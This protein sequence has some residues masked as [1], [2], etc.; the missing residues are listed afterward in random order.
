MRQKTDYAS[1]LLGIIILVGLYVISLRSYILFHGLAEVFS[2]VIAFSIFILAW[3][4]RALMENS[5]LLYLGIAYLFIGGLDLIHTFAYRGMGV[6][7]GHT[8]NLPTQLWVAARYMESFSLL[9]AALFL[10]RRLKATLVL[11]CYTVIS[12]F[13]VGSIFFWHVFPICFVEG[14]G[15]TA[16]KKISEYAVSFVLLGAVISIIRRRDHFDPRVLRLLVASILLT[17]ASE[18]AFTFYIH[19]YGLSNLI[20]HYLKIVSFYLIY[21]ALIETGLRQPYN[22]LFRDLKQR[23]EQ[24]R[25]SEHRYRTLFESTIVGIVSIG[26]DR[27]IV[28]ANRALTGMLGYRDQEEL[29]GQ[30]AQILLTDKEDA[31]RATEEFRE[32]G[33]FGPREVKLR[34]KQG[35]TVYVLASATVDRDADGQIL[36]FT[37]VLADITDRKKAEEII[38]RDKETLEQMV[39][40]RS[41]ELVE[42][43]DRLA[44]A[45]RLSGIGTL[46]AT[47][48]HELRNPLGVIQ[49]ALINM[50]RKRKEPALDK[51]FANIEKKVSDSTQII[52]NLLRYSRI[53]PPQYEKANLFEILGEAIESGRERFHDQQVEVVADIDFLKDTA[54]DADILQ[55]REVFDNIL[56]NAYQAVMDIRGKIEIRGRVGPSEHITISMTDNGVGITREDLKRVFEPFF[57]NKARGTGLGLTICRELV[58]L[59]GGTV[60]IESESGQGTTVRVTLP[61]KRARPQPSA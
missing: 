44:E 12:V 3:N 23:E 60:E 50:K 7:P 42:A 8:T 22:L 25:A 30:N 41:E 52:D 4:S 28:S 27:E 36:G 39:K 55:I 51:H 58:Q 6:F 9:L 59:H 26:L 56:N 31:A 1:V 17:I 32:T 38:K 37:G 19:A 48:A 53:K 13:F 5:Y 24:L 16:F 20:G 15:L 18:V 21:K 34:T 54:V 29:I 43:H 46:A 10:G 40:Q 47:V 45:K 2:I 57:T 49:A 11:L 14:Q 61:V 35:N 33:H